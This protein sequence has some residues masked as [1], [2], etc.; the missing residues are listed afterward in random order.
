MKSSNNISLQGIL[1]ALL[2]A[3][4]LASASGCGSKPGVALNDSVQKVSRVETNTEVVKA[5]VMNGA[6]ADVL[7]HIDTSDDIRVFPQS[8]DE[9][10]KNAANHLKR[11]NIQ[12]V[13]QIASFIDGGGVVNLGHRTGLY[14]RV[15]WVIPASEPVGANPISSFK[16][17]LVEKRGYRAADLEDLKVDGKNITGEL[18]GMPITV[19]RIEDMEIG[20]DETAIL[21]IDLAY[22][23]GQKAQHKEERMGTRVLFDFLRILR[24]KRILTTQVTINL[25]TLDNI[26]PMDMR[27]FGTVIEDALKDPK[28][29]GGSV[30]DK[31]SMMMDAEDALLAG[32][33]NKSEDIYKVL[34]D[35]YPDD[36]G[37][38]FSLAVARGF[39]GKGK[40]SSEAL[41]KAYLA[42][43]AYIR[44]FFQLARVLAVNDKL[45]AGQDILNSSELKAIVPQVELDYQMGL[46]FFNARAYHDAITYLELVLKSRRDDF[47]LKTVL[48]K[49]YKEVGD[50]RKMYNTL[51]RLIKLD[52]ERVARDMPWVFLDFGMLCEQERLYVTAA[53]NYQKY[54]NYV[55]SA[56]NADELKEKIKLYSKEKQ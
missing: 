24:R 10:L 31:Y 35:R 4:L 52:E 46:F 42:D 8:F 11:K 19:T 13:D 30:P 1:T 5:W 41:G 18:A 56:E 39:Q 27:F 15:I 54:L 32:Q 28:I 45:F 23:L 2:L 16:S 40:E 37:I 33:F 47:A 53:E 12:V 9:T 43:S 25:S 44:G 51:Y 14:K 55:P 34:S 50:T 38:F 17:V 26:V 7:I 49:A 6:S 29:V 22:F 21:D 48:Y 36:A 3:A 20:P